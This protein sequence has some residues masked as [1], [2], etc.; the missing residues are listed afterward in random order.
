MIERNEKA[1]K[2]EEKAGGSEVG[3]GKEG[4]QRQEAPCHYVMLHVAKVRI[5]ACSLFAI[6]K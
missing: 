2:I 5:S 6:L 1:N 3:K 4:R